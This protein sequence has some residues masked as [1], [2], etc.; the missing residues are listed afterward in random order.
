[1]TLART[2]LWPLP[3]RSRAARAPLPLTVALLGLAGAALI[4]LPLAG[5]GTRV[6]WGRL[7]ELLSSPSATA[8]LGLS[9]RTC[10][11]STTICVLLGA[12]LALLLSRQWRGVRLARVLAVLPMTMPPVVAGIALLATLGKKGVLGGVLD[13][14][15]MRIAFSTTAVVIA[16]VF[17]A[18]PFLVVTLE[19][20][21][22]SRDER[23]EMIART[24]GAGPWRLLVR[25]TLP[26]VGPA[27]ARGT[28]LAL[29]RG[30]GEFGATIAFAGS[31]EGVT[32]TMPLAI[33]L[34][35]EEDT[36]TALALAVVLIAAA[37]LVVG[38]TTVPWGTLLQRWL[39][40]AGRSP[41]PSGT[42][43]PSALPPVPMPA[44]QDE[45]A[46]P[47][48]QRNARRLPLTISFTS[49][50]RDVS[51]CLEIGAGRRLA[52]IG[53]N[54]SGKSTACLVAAGLLDA[55]GGEV[56]LG[57]RV[58][59]GTGFVPAG[60]RGI[61]LLS[62]EP[63]IFAHMSVLENVA[64]GPRCQGLGR[65]AARERARAELVSVGAEHLAG[66][67]GGALSG[68]QAAR[69]ALARALATSPRALI[70][71][72]PMA[73]LDAG[74]RQ[75]MRS[76]V[77]RRASEE[78]LTVLL[79]THDV[80]DIASLAD[81]VVVL[82]AGRVVERGEAARV[83]SAPGS[84]FTARLTGMSIL[85]GTAAGSREDPRV[86]LGAGMVIHGRPDQEVREGEP[87]AALIPPEAVALYEEAPSGSPR[88]ALPAVVR[89][90]E[91]SG[92]LVSVGLES[93]GHR[94][95]ASVTAA[96]VAQLGIAPN[97]ELIAIIKAVEVRVVP[98][99]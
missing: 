47:H 63:G 89:T 75:E 59:D 43:H 24:L 51:V 84:D 1:M 13:A 27:L 87:A 74:A 39:L 60:Q 88:N 18:M 34:Q 90:V 42:E 52:L 54:G 91:R 99:G 72:E 61:A 36:A 29:G 2:A 57:E 5:M 14:W 79:V 92:A 76:L 95:A 6:A 37:A 97:R 38:A 96:A 31:K 19:A 46:L 56:R 78:G 53:P 20:A 93:G 83:L 33:Y 64:F 32:R 21:L 66:R 11:A 77:T 67:S 16:Q 86:D 28:A 70:L 48:T 73:A 41:A 44:S 62:Q 80:L 17:V 15:G 22:R 65:R 68:G 58:L 4:I 26:M 10:L 69:V 23:A 50:E 45:P 85:M 81:D 55:T 94:L 30:L 25:I 8:A 98:R 3:R 9:L 71:D 82:E 35:R 49:A 7:P 40:P 12:P